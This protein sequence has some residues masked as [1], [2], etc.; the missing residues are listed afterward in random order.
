MENARY[1][2][3]N[4]FNTLREEIA[5]S[6]THG[7]GAALSIAGLVLMLSLAARTG[8]GWRIAGVV[9]YG[10]SLVLLYLASTL[11]HAF[12]H[13]PIKRFWRRMDHIGI[14]CLIAGSYTPFLLVT[15]R[16]TWGWILLGIIWTLAALGIVFKMFFMD[17]FKLANV[18]IY[19]LMGWLIVLIFGPLASQLGTAGVAW[20]IAG[21]LAYT[22]G[23]AFFVWERLPY[24]H[25][26]WHLFVMAGSACH[27][28]AV[29]FHVLP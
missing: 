23:V 6:I 22:G 16:G 4:A 2:I 25:A 29:F 11:Y 15:L 26:V 19:L 1:E 17:R 28:C 21:G 24:N 9:V 3:E 20:L 8:D 12:Q 27:F 18:A 14:Y 5:N 13:P 7:I 10:S